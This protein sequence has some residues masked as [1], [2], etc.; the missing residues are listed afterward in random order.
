MNTEEIQDT[1]NNNQEENEFNLLEFAIQL[2]Q[3]WYWI[4]ISVAVALCI[5]IFCMLRTTPTYTRSTSLLIKSEDGKPAGSGMGVLASDFQNLGSVLGSNTNINNEMYTIGA[6]VVMQEVAK[7]LHLDVQME[8]EQGLHNVPLYEESPIKLLMPQTKDDDTFC[9]KMRLHANQTAELWDFETENGQIDKHVTIKMGTLAHTPVGIVVIQ[10]TSYWHKHFFSNEITVNKYPLEAVGNM[11]NSRLSVALSDK[12][13]TIV[14]ISIT[15]EDKQRAEDILYKLIDVYNEQWLKDRNRVAE[16]TF[17]FITNRLNTLTKE[18]GDVDQKI[19][20]YKSQNKMPDIDAA[21]NMYMAQNSKNNDQILQLSNQLGV[22][23]YIREYLNDHSKRNQYLP[24]N[25]GIGSTGIEAMIDNYNKTVS[26]RN[27]ILVNSSE[28]SPL[29]QKFNNDLAQQRQTI[30]HS[31]DNLIV[32]LQSQV[33]SWQN[34]EAQTNEKLAAAPQQVKQ[35]LSVGRQQKVKEALYIYL[36]QKREEN[37]L[38]KTYTAWNTR[39]I[40]PPM[41]SKSPTSP[42]KYMILLI[43]LAI[44]VCIPAGIIFLM[45]TLN[46]T[47][48]GRSDLEKLSIPLIGEIP[49]FFSNKKLWTSR[50]TNAKRQVYVKKDCRDLINESFRMLRTKLDYFIKPFGA[51]KKI[52]LVTSF[53]VGAGKSFISANLSEALALKDCRVLAIDFDMRHASLSTLGEKQAQGLS[54][55]LCGIEA[56]VSKLIQHNP[57]DYNFDILPV[58]VI[59][60]NPAELL[61]SPK[62]TEMLDKLRLEYDYIILDCPPIDIVTDTSIIKNYSDANLFVVRV[63]LMDRRSL[64]DIEKF[65]KKGI[66]KNMALILNGTK[67]VSNRY[68][69]FRYGYSYGYNSYGYSSYIDRKDTYK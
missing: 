32:Q 19:S 16:S 39:I 11:Y 57:N 60:P 6:P 47:V 53:N 48:R 49:H 44:G 42:R 26:S 52:I 22:A 36:L 5:A 25:T 64:K 15:D 29:V 34:T 8:V 20:D 38:S 23:R 56:D 66:F 67:Y 17:E 40:Q 51:D 4:A 69:N 41:G 1:Q 27:D 68:G 18:L 13:S 3:N 62:V 33:N 46:H 59:P 61:L 7:R 14:N 43:A 65:Y 12:E 54:A 30:M 63:G 9:F 10:P 2:L 28:N 24:T 50:K 37:E 35:L 45:Q 21:S 58:G 31:L 55:Y